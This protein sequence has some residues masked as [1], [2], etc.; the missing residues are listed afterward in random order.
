MSCAAHCQALI[1]DNFGIVTFFR[2]HSEEMTFQT[3]NFTIFQDS[4]KVFTEV[5]QMSVIITFNNELRMTPQ[6]Y[7][8]LI[9]NNNLL[10]IN[11]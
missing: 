8:L 2:S 11:Y 4:Q 9:I 3:V 7:L 1:V 10:I 6:A 5:F